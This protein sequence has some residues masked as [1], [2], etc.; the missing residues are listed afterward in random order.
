M[1]NLQKNLTTD[2]SHRAEHFYPVKIWLK[3]FLKYLQ[4]TVVWL[5]CSNLVMMAMFFDKS[6]NP[7]SVLCKI[8][9]ETLI[10][11][12]DCNLS[13]SFRGKEFWKIVNN[14]DNGHQVM[15]IAHLALGPGELKIVQIWHTSFQVI[16]MLCET[17]AWSSIL[18]FLVRL[19]KIF[20]FEQL[21]Y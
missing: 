15:A 16:Q 9:Q 13:S 21:F 17:L 6:K 11:M 3:Q 8:P 20:N 19:M 18:N 2:R 5:L 1:T 4:K 7:T 14:D 10:Q 12:F